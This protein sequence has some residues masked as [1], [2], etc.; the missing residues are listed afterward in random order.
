MG[1][2]FSKAAE[3]GS[4]TARSFVK[5]VP[6]TPYT[7]LALIVLGEVELTNYTA[8]VF[9]WYDG[10]KKLDQIQI[11]TNSAWNAYHMTGTNPNSHNAQILTTSNMYNSFMWL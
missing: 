4:H 2:P 11:Q 8:Y 1:L 6:A 9:G 5:S 10:A 7:A 3:G